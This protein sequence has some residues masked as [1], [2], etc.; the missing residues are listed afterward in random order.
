MPTASVAIT[1]LDRTSVIDAVP[2]SSF[3]E[4][5]RAPSGLMANCSGS[6][7]AA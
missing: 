7:P 6:L 3:A 4:N 5:R 2:A 1:C